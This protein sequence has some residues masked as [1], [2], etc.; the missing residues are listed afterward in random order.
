MQTSLR[1][2]LTFAVGAVH[3]LATLPMVLRSVPGIVS[4]GV[5]GGIAWGLPEP[6]AAPSMAALF[7]ALLSVELFLIAGL[8]HRMEV[9]GVP[10]PRWVGLTFIV[11]GLVGGVLMPLS[12]FW[13]LAALGGLYVSGR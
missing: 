1:V 3:G 2:R 9:A 13:L 4:H 6:D 7:S 11:G 8:V 12:G 5:I 10:V